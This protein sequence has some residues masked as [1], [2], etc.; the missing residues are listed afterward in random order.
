MQDHLPPINDLSHDD[1]VIEAAARRI[2]EA[3]LSAGG[4]GSAYETDFWIKLAEA[5]V[6]SI[7]PGA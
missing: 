7:P 1:P 6:A 4:D 5:G 3:I 2:D